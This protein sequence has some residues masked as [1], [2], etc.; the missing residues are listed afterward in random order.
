MTMETED[1]ISALVNDAKIPIRRLRPPGSRVALWLSLSAPWVALVVAQMG[2]RPDFADKLTEPVWMIEQ[3]A[4]LM[5]ATTAALAAFCVGV[6]GRPSWE[7]LV[8]VFP[9]LVWL[10]TL[11]V[12]CLQEL[13]STRPLEFQSDWVCLPGIMMVGLVPGAAM[14]YM[15][16]RGAPLAPVFSV[17]LGGLAA[18]ALADFGLRLFHPQDARLMVMVWQVGSVAL[19]TAL[20]ALLGPRLVRWRHSGAG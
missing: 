11:S 20:S 6:P 7:R 1:L 12:G 18:A 19:L 3:A 9:L 15:L 13:G 17:G 2:L 16:Y 5:V 14:A 10:G 4:A 8:P